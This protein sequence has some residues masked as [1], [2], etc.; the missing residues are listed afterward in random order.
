M[1]RRHKPS[2]PK[3]SD[4]AHT[5]PLLGLAHYVNSGRDYHAD[6]QAARAASL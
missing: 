5:P 1:T 4:H 6:Q 2:I 3:F